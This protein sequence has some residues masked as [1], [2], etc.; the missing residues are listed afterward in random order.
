MNDDALERGE[1]APIYQPAKL[2]RCQPPEVRLDFGRKVY[3]T[4]MM[5]LA[6]GSAVASPWV[7]RWNGMAAARFFFFH[8]WVP[9][10]LCVVAVTMQIVHFGVVWS[11][12][13]PLLSEAGFTK[14]YMWLL[15]TPP[16]SMLYLLLYSILCGVIAGWT[17]VA[18]TKNSALVVAGIGCAVVV[19]ITLVAVLIPLD[20]AE[21]AGTFKTIM[22]VRSMFIF[23][24]ILKFI[25][26][27]DFFWMMF[28]GAWVFLLGFILATETQL[29]F[30]TARP[31]Q[32]KVEYTIDMYAF[33]AFHL[34]HI[35]I[36]FLLCL[37]HELAVPWFI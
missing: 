36:F 15:R 1:E 30:G 33:A 11:I 14:R 32:Q 37:L 8:P 23:G 35:I 24:F 5:L 20:L 13:G 28:I 26:V 34:V 9:Q 17:C 16:Y 3:I 31:R 7:F 29:I 12:L 18:Y 27:S 10:V 4:V 2:L 19:L 21:L 6:V 25:H 22:V